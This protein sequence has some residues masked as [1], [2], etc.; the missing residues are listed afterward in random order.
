LRKEERE[1]SLQVSPTYKK[2]AFWDSKIAGV[3][4]ARE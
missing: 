2:H 4:E 1:K 3:G